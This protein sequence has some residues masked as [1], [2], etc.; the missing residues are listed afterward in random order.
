MLGECNLTCEAEAPC[1]LAKAQQ[2]R[3]DKAAEPTLL[4][5]LQTSR[6]FAVE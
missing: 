1:R 3:A 4:L 6:G 2:S 5:F